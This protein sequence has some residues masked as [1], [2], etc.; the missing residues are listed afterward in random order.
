MILGCNSVCQH[1][2]QGVARLDVLKN[3]NLE[4]NENQIVALVG[5]SG[6]G[7]ST[8]L[9]ILGLLEKP[10]SG[11]VIIDQQ[12][13]STAHYT[14]KIVTQIRKQ[15]IGFIY[16]FHHLLPQFSALENV[17]LPLILQGFHK[18]KALSQSKTLLEKL[19]LSKRLHHMPSQLSG[20]EQQRV[21]IAR[22]LIHQP[23]ILLADEPTGNL[24]NETAKIVFNELLDLVRTQGVC[25]LVATHDLTLAQQMDKTL[26]LHNGTLARDEG[27]S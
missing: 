2:I 17:S 14:D 3:I 22:A 6:S 23:K 20:G 1:F 10:Q 5:A 9:H 7:K 8:L 4:I 15:K 12:P 27:T 24:D 16:Q 18:E 21:A 19:N 11:T 26:T 25:A 13:I